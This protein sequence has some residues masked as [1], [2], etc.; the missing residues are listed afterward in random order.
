MASTLRC[1]PMLPSK[2]AV[3]A[4]LRTATEITLAG[5]EASAGAARDEVGSAET[6]QEGKY[7]TRATEASYLAR[8]QAWMVAELRRL[9]AWYAALRAVDLEYV[10]LGALVLLDGEREELIFLAPVGGGAVEVDGRRIR[11]VSPSSPIG[12]AMADLRRG[13]SFEFDSPGGRV[14]LEVMD[15]R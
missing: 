12:S 10:Q 13:D 11:I 4:A 1:A 8:G 2:H 6:R 15:V 3:V 5:V 14:E 9:A 7:D